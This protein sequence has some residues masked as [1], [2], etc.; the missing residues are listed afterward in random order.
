M[1]EDSLLTDEATGNRSIRLILPVALK[2][3]LIRAEIV[4]GLNDIPEMRV[5]FFCDDE[6]ADMAPLVGQP[7]VIEVDAPLS[8]DP[9]VEL[10][11]AQR[12]FH[13]ICIS[14]EYLGSTERRAIYEAEFR[15]WPWLLTQRADCKIFQEM[16]AQDI[17][18]EVFGSA[19][20]SDYEFRLNGTPAER[21]YC[22]QYRETDFNFVRRLMEE[23]GMYFFFEYSD[24]AAKLV[25]VDDM[26]KHDRI[27]HTPDIEFL[28][29]GTSIRA[30][31]GHI[32]EW[33]SAE[34]VRT[35]KISLNDY[36]FETPSADLLV[37]KLSATA[38]DHSEDEHEVY[39]YPGLY[40]ETAAGENNATTRIDAVSA[41]RQ[42]VRG[43]CNVR[44]AGAGLRFDMLEHPRDTENTEYLLVKATHRLNLFDVVDED[45]AL[46]MILDR[47]FAFPDEGLDE[48]HTVRFEAMRVT[49]PFRPVAIT[50]R[51]VIP[52]IQTAIVVGS[53]GEEIWTD[54]HGRV[55]VQFHWD[56]IGEMNENSSCWIRVAT[57]W[58]GKRWGWVAI[59]R[60]G[61]EVV[62]QFEEGNPDRPIVT[63]ML[64][65]AENMPPYEL[66]ANQTQ[67]GLKTNSSKGGD[68]AH[69]LMFEDK[70]DQELIRFVSERDYEQLVKNN[71]TIE[72]GTVHMDGGDL[73]QT[74]YANKT[75][76]IQTGD[77]TLTVEEGNRSV[78]ISTG[79][80]DET[81]SQG[82]YGLSV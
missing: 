30:N 67:L 4:E 63:G 36:N 29:I 72:I 47:G 76:T 17:I 13:G 26:S 71:A 5:Q 24:T 3:H 48:H 21:L 35:G 25:I 33:R 10:E 55:K 75:E 45:D 18:S 32:F 8:L 14:V 43:L 58:T 64:Y 68:G 16:T 46:G 74:V 22:V 52:G 50:P 31:K 69:E 2:N 49:E 1:S 65:H 6:N 53:S 59:P 77:D 61:Q 40:K 42:R 19:G 44:W 11:T 70:K 41:E 80:Y 78:T 60:I 28:P 20:F 62:V 73:T 12:Y 37:S 66:S 7:M 9:F 34:G 23:E 57:P 39:D 27:P 79:D 51:P 54:E 56:R 81:V 38:L 82:N 15:P